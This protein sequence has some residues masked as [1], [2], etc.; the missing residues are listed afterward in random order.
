[1]RKLHLEGLYLERM[2][3]NYASALNLFNLID[4]NCVFDLIY[5]GY[6]R[7]FGEDR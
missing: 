7:L 3:D 2:K 6:E 1:M 4:D 5:T